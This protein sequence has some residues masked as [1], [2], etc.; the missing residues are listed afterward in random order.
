M[1]DNEP[2]TEA[3]DTAATAQPAASTRR[4]AKKAPAAKKTTT[5]KRTVKTADAVPTQ[6]DAEAA[7]PAPAP[8]K[9]AAAKKTAAKKTTAKKAAAKAPAKK[10]ARAAKKTADQDIFPQFV[11][12]EAAETADAAPAK[13][14]ARKRT[15]KKTSAPDLLSADSPMT[16]GPV[17]DAERAP[18]AAANTSADDAANAGTSARKR[19]SRRRTAKTAESTANAEASP[20]HADAPAQA[21]SAAGTTDRADSGATSRGRRGRNRGAAEANSSAAEANSG[22]TTALTTDHAGPSNTS[23][24]SSTSVDGAASDAPEESGTRRTRRRAAAPAAVLFQAP[25]GGPQQTAPQQAE[26]TAVEATSDEPPEPGTD[27]QPTGNRRRRSRRNRDAEAREIEVAEESTDAQPQASADDTD[28]AAEKTT[29]R[30]R[31]RSARKAAAAQAAGSAT[32]GGATAD[33]T[34]PGATAAEADTAADDESDGAND[35]QGED[36]EEGGEGTRRRRRRRGGR[37]RRKSGD[38][39]DDNADDQSDDEDEHDSQDADQDADA[40]DDGDQDGAADSDEDGEAG[41]SSRRRRRRR[42]RKGEDSAASPDDPDETVVRVREPRSKTVNNEITAVE[43]STRLEA[44]KQRRREGRAAGRR[45]APIVTEAEFLARR[46]SVE[47]TMVIRSREDLTQIAVS[48]D[49]V[50]VEHYVTTAEQTSLIGNVYLGRVQNVLPSMEAAFIDIGKGRNAVLYAGEVDWAT[51]GGAN[52]PRKIEQVL[53]SGQSV[54]VQVTK[55][56]IGHKGARLTNQIS[57][58][59]RYVVYVP[60]GGNGGISRKLPDTERNRLKT[61]LKDIVPDEAGVIVRTAAEGASEEELTADVSRLQSAWEDIDKKSKNGQAPQLLY[62]EPDLLIRVVRDLFT[63]DFAKL[64]ISGDRA[65]EQVREYVAGVA[66]HLAD[67]V[68][69]WGGD[70]DVFANYRIDEQIKKALDRKVWLPSGGSL[71]IDRTEAMTVVDVNTGKFTG[72][73]GNLEETVT[74]NNLEAAEEIVRQ[75]RLRD[76]GGIIVIDFID[77]VLESNRDLVLRRLVECLGRDRTKHQVAEVTSL[78]LVQMTRKRIGTGLLEAFSENCDHCGGRGLILHDEPKES[79][80]RDSRNG[81]SNGNGQNNGQG[82]GQANGNGHDHGKPAQAE[83]GGRKSSRRRRGKGRGEEEATEAETAQHNADAAQ[84]LAQIAAATVKKDGEGT[85]EPT[86]YPISADADE[87]VSP[88]ATGFP[89]ESAAATTLIT[90]TP[91]GSET[92]GSEVGASEAA[93]PADAAQNGATKS[94]RRRRSSRSRSK[95]ATEGEGAEPSELVTT[96]S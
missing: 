40:S 22:A 46:E 84:K 48:E 26:P 47:R 18:N 28:P 81:Q 21:D 86:G 94:T 37:R 56:P 10:T 43:G 83:E 87:H 23:G 93:D 16:D 60:R 67:R 2:T 31:S 29:T 63:E 66:P 36:G 39:A 19:T 50:L 45:R 51:L 1:L 30:T 17:A 52:G 73:G 88:E 85:P 68:E 49:N 57:L 53:K 76:I 9:K 20:A 75:L 42:R 92:A 41:S 79:R 44:K 91:A 12:D 15:T 35:V 24:S 54:L 14:T 69:K 78:G 89:A 8:A 55:D 27:E 59:G 7:D 74:K 70:G 65:Y 71:I 32:T 96:G 61:I 4:T 58:P 62:G 82:N 77:M 80:R 3:A 11:P 95:T 72:S 90:E 13:K 25:T 34:A 38:G 5:R 6:S 64:V 33:A